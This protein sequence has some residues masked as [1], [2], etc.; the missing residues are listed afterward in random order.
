MTRSTVP[1]T[2]KK[3]KIEAI[4]KLMRN[5]EWRTGVTGRE[6]AEKWDMNYDT[7][8]HLAAEAS[9]IVRD[10]VTNPD[11]ITRTVGAAL[12]EVIHRGLASGDNKAVVMAA[13]TWAEITGSAA[14][15]Q[16]GIQITESDLSTEELEARLAALA[17]KARAETQQNEPGSDDIEEP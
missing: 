14:P 4:C 12:Q 13:K 6:L 16:I 15:R 7:I 17:S 1:S 10:E 2:L 5:L 11:R 9:K 8:K 3:V